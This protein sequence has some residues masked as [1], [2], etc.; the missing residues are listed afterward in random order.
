MP[1][2]TY[3]RKFADLDI[4]LKNVCISNG[5]VSTRAAPVGLEVNLQPVLLQLQAGVTAVVHLTHTCQGRR[6]VAGDGLIKGSL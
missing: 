4:Q 6:D 2:Q 1:S 3:Q 5:G